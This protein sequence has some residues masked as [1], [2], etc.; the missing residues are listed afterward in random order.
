MDGRFTEPVVGDVYI[1]THGTW[2]SHVKPKASS[3]RY[4]D[5]LHLYE[6]GATFIVLEDTTTLTTLL[7]QQGRTVYYSAYLYCDTWRRL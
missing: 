3:V 2:L 5:S 1:L 4:G 6:K 7:D